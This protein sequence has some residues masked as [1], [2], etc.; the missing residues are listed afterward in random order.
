MK[1]VISRLKWKQ[2]R[3]LTTTKG[4][5][6]GQS[7][8]ITVAPDVV[9]DL[10]WHPL[11]VTIAINAHSADTHVIERYHETRIAGAPIDPRFAISENT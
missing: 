4:S 7:I 10:A 8:H 9:R 3:Y 1:I 6:R 2:N 5:L 11:V